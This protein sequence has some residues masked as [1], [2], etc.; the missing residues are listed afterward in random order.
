LWPS[1]SVALASDSVAIIHRARGIGNADVS[2]QHAACAPQ[3]GEPLWFA[4]TYQLD[5]L[6]TA[7]KLK[8]NTQLNITLASSFVRYLALPPQQVRMSSAEKFAYATAAYREI[9]GV[10]VNDWQIQL[11]DA[12]PSQTTIV[13]A[14]DKR[15]L[16]T[17]S[18]VAQNHQLKL[19]CIQPYL[20]VAFNGLHQQI[21]TLNGFLVIVESDRLLLVFVKQG[22]CQH[23]RVHLVAEDWQLELKRLMMR[24][25][26]LDEASNDLDT[27]EI[28]IY[29]PTHS[30]IALNAIPG[31]KVKRVG[32]VSNKLNLTSL[33][34]KSQNAHHFA[35][36]EL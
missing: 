10:A 19:K 31:W 12:S 26:L 20:M 7:F 30:N 28:S 27:K 34:L 11:D 4:A 25:S 24:E 2:Q 32:A 5:Q 22:R 16:A 36:L 33:N 13:A 6:L 1:Q 23:L 21:N 15:L 29:A 17:L 14:V 18:Q 8:S 35:M 3:A 9:Y